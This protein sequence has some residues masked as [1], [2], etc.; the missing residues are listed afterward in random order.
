M[1]EKNIQF[2]L[3]NFINDFILHRWFIFLFTLLGTSLFILIAFLLPKQYI[4]IASVKSSNGSN[5]FNIGSLAKSAGLNSGV[6][7]LMDF[8]TSSGGGDVDFLFS[9]LNSRSVL[10]S[11][12]Y[13]LDLKTRYSANEIEDTREILIGN[14][15]VDVDY[16]SGLLYFGVYDKDPQ[17][18]AKLTNLFIY[19]LNEK[20]SFLSS[21]AAKN[22]RL[23]LEERYKN[24]LTDLRMAE[25]SLSAFQEK[26][27]V[28]DP[29]IQTE[30]SLRAAANLKAE[31]MLK[32]IEADTRR[33]I[34]GESSPQSKIFQSQITEL[35]NKYSQFLT[36][37]NDSK[38][39]FIPFEKVPGLGMQ[40]LR[41]FR[42]VEI[43]SE[44]M[45]IIIPLIEQA[46]IQ[47]LKKTPS[48]LVLDTGVVPEKK[49]KPRR[50]FIVLFGF[51]LSFSLSFIY[52]FGKINLKNLKIHNPSAY[53]KIQSIIKTVTADFR[54]T[55]NS[56]DR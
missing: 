3:I 13:A 49:S 29:T 7:L 27:D 23:N 9:I 11:V 42:R 51:A 2:K 18:A 22:V 34:L 8:A 16:P 4:T 48:L 46:K 53:Q 33:R 52:I 43:N 5:N 32:E 28:L 45:K 10:D 24:V 12:I 15:S 37:L 6:G 55:K 14:M 26:Y 20:Y 1:E 17:L 19:Y 40:Y 44:M 50:L 30:I 54:F 47:E 21:E 41:L 36:G 38:D 56:D 35:K 25:D 39:I 31:L